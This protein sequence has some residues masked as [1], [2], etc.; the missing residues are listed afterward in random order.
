VSLCFYVVHHLWPS[1][2]AGCR[3]RTD[4]IL[5]VEQP[6][7]SW[8]FKMHIM[9]KVAKE[10]GLS[11]GFI[12]FHE[13]VGFVFIFLLYFQKTFHSFVILYCFDICRSSNQS[14]NPEPQEEDN[15]L[16]GC[17]W[18]WS[19]KVQP[20][21]VQY[22]E[23]RSAL[24]FLFRVAGVQFISK[25]MEWKSQT[26]QTH[27]IRRSTEPVARRINA[28]LRKAI[29]VLQRSKS[30]AIWSIMRCWSR[31]AGTWMNRFYMT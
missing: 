21:L 8:A 26:C 20:P 4:L 31:H 24:Y 6:A 25:W 1:C 9:K 7:S 15:H 12:V 28:K 11:L 22:P 10:W 19:W 14:V 5:I 27:L 18:T 30:V 13:L 3:L 23:R 29:K 17:I 2:W 16:H